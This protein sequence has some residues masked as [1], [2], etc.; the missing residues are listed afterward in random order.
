MYFNRELLWVMIIAFFSSSIMAT[1]G[2]FNDDGIA[3]IFERKGSL[4]HVLLLGQEGNSVTV[5]SLRKLSLNYTVQAIADFNNDGIADIFWR[6]GFKNYIWYMNED[7]THRYKNIGNLSSRYTV[8]GV[9]D[10]N[11][12]GVA[13]IFWRSGKKNYIW[14]MTSN[15]KHS[16]ENIGN[17][18]TGYRVVAVDDF[19]NDKITDILWR[20]RNRTY[21]W[22]MQSTGKHKYR[23]IGNVST[24]YKIVGSGD[25]NRD[26]I[27]D[28]LWKRGDSNYL[29]YMKS[30]GSHTYKKIASS[31]KVFK[32]I[33]DY[34]GDGIKDILWVNGSSYT[35]WMMNVNG[36]FEAIEINVNDKDN[37]TTTEMQTLLIPPLASYKMVEG[38]KVFNMNIQESEHEFFKGVKT[39]TYGVNSDILGETIRIHRGDDVKIVYNNLLKEAT[40]MHGH[41]MHVPATMDGGPKNKIQPNSSWTA[42]YTVNQKA[43]TNWYHPHLMGKTAEHVYMGLAGFILIDD[44]ESDALDLP[45]EYG[46]DDIPL[47]LQDKRFDNA[48]QIDYSPS[49]QEIRQGY[50]AETMLVNG[51]IEP[52][53][54]V[55]AKKIRFRLLN[56]SN[57]RVFK[58]AF[59]DGRKFYQIATDNSFLE[60]PVELSTVILTPGE[61]VEIV[62]DF[63]DDL[64]G[65]IDLMDTNSNKKMMSIKVNKKSELQTTLPSTLTT[66]IKLNP[67]DAVRTRKF[68]LGMSRGSGGMHMSI[69]GK[70]MDMS[71]IDEVVPMD[72]VEIWEISN[73][74]GMEH[75]FHI[76]STHFYP[77]ERNGSPANILPSE[78]GYKDTIRLA[79]R[80]SIK[81]IVKMT[82][83]PD[84][85]NGYMYHCHFLEHEDDG[86]MGQ[87]TIT[88]GNAVVNVAGTTS[89]SMGRR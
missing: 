46:V 18:S 4:N 88:T 27:S 28:V 69:N 5:Q 59:L 57:A 39:K 6:S 68:V 61:R 84:D 51:T 45:K 85:E 53:V 75:N 70:T 79:P 52:F 54:N 71:R 87:F 67:L 23:N 33:A 49:T 43:S 2:D 29:W 13:D 89:S 55:K 48:Q 22:Y 41:G 66:H 60:E 26:G 8:S 1:E 24:S 82:D 73:T 20:N 37:E 21:I 80:D 3:D 77:L 19:N 81:I 32:T 25:F 16:Y 42:Q 17:L 74:M 10:F 65:K 40:T 47:V 76:H 36:D 50:R 62:V 34:N 7:G 86:M 35:A 56:G 30:D 44:D 58:L 64:N 31:S 11:G 38:Y 63:K 78:Q 15:G 83:F 9:G 14:Y 12:D 72:E